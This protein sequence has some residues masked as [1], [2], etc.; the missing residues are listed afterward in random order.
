MNFGREED[1]VSAIEYG[2]TVAIT[3]VIAI[4]LSRMLGL[5]AAGV[6]VKAATALMDTFSDPTSTRGRGL[7]TVG[8]APGCAADVRGGHG[9]RRRP[10]L[11]GH[12]RL[13]RVGLVEAGTY[14]ARGFIGCRDAHVQGSFVRGCV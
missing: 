1:G 13:L 12:V 6:F 7:G 10:L 2:L 8:T 11:G 14:T 3:T 5:S 4:T 9:S